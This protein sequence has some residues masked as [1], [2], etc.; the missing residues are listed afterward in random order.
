[1]TEVERGT[2]R[3]GRRAID[4]PSPLLTEVLA[5]CALSPP[6][7]QPQSCCTSVWSGTVMS[8]PSLSAGA[9]ARG[10]TVNVQ[11]TDRCF[12]PGGASQGDDGGG[13]WRGAP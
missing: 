10:P 4:L 1:M 13:D 7:P 5:G 12:S 9:G 8:L 11:W 6:Q 3:A 2:D